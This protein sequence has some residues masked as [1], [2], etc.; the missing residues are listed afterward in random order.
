MFLDLGS[1]FEAD[2]SGT[3]PHMSERD[4]V[5]WKRWQAEHG[6]EYE[7]FYFDAAVGTPV[8]LPEGLSERQRRGM[9]RSSVK[10][11]DAIGVQRGR[12]R[13][14]EAR[15]SAS[16]SAGGAVLQYLFLLSR[17]GA[18]KEPMQ[19]MIITDLVDPDALAWFRSLAILVEAV[20]PVV[21][22]VVFG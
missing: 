22:P 19:G 8:E 20:G 18:F 16:S 2:W 12:V 13:I 4:Y 1:L 14:I 5:I 3:P 21:S 9:E 6:K 17:A 10:R 11:I 7:G 15:P